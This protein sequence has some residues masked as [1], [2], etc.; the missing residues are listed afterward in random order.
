MSDILGDPYSLSTRAII[1]SNRLVHEDVRQILVEADAT[2]P[3][4]T[5]Q[6]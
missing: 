2:R 4:T 5:P 6:L 1:G 3:D